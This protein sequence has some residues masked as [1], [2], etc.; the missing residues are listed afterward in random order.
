MKRSLPRAILFF[1][2]PCL[3]LAGSRES[4]FRAQE[5]AGPDV[6]SQVIRIENAEPRETARLPEHFYGL[7]V[8]FADIVW[9]Y[10]E[11]DGTQNL[12]PRRG[13]TTADIANL[14][15]LLRAVDPHW[16]G[17][18]VATQPPLPAELPLSPPNSCFP[19]CVAQWQELMRT[20]RPPKEARL[21][22][23]Y[24][25]GR[26]TGHMLLEFRKG[27]SRYVYDPERSLQPIRLRWGTGRDSLA[28]ANAILA[29]RW[30]VPP[31]RTST[32]DLAPIRRASP[33]RLAPTAGTPPT[34][35][36][37]R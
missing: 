23:C 7:V 22:A 2:L 1:L 34:Q 3:A 24:A 15:E 29:P 12:S 16:V 27:W 8:V 36:R 25:P 5:L 20:K 26:I 4:A 21:I 19:A 37:S 28:V 18:E 33:P 14:G 9:L 13:Q 32:V 17:F 11:F 31:A 6:W 35:E 30:E 10:T